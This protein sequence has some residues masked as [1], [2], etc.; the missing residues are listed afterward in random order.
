MKNNGL[1][2]SE[3][4]DVI[5]LNLEELISVNEQFLAQ[6]HGA[7]TS[8]I[9]TGDEVSAYSLLIL[10]ESAHIILHVFLNECGVCVLFPTKY[11]PPFV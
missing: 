5:F 2:N 8:A 9:E 3:Q 6:L 4:L 10:P 11:V 7:M 1:L